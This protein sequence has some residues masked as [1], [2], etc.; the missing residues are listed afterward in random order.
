MKS[1]ALS[2][3]ILDLELLSIFNK[4][5]EYAQDKALASIYVDAI[6]FEATGKEPGGVPSREEFEFGGTEKY[7]GI[8][9]YGAAPNY[10]KVSSPYAWLFGKEYSRI[11]TG[12]AMDFAYVAAVR[13]FVTH[14][15]ET[16]AL[17]FEII[18][19]LGTFRPSRPQNGLTLE[20][21]MRSIDPSKAE[22]VCSKWMKRARS[23]G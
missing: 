18:E 1:V 21:A 12:S 7:R 14:I 16:G 6:I 2:E 8:A 13:T 11:K 17:A 3:C 22:K 20:E 15:L 9:K 19:E 4:T 23:E 5:L 10:F